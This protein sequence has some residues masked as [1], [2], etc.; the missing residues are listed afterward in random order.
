MSNSINTTNNLALTAAL[1]RGEEEAFRQLFDEYYYRLV[2]FANRLLNDLDLSRSTVQ[3]VF[4][5]LFDK[6]DEITVHTSLNALLHQMVRNRCL[7]LLKRDKMKRNHHQQIL[8]QVDEIEQ[9]LETLE[10]NE[11]ENAIH[12]IVNDLPAQCQRI[13]KLS[14][15]QGKSNQEI[16]DKL[17]LSKRTVE[18]QISNAL[19]QLRIG[20]RRMQLMPLLILFCFLPHLFYLYLK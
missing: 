13:F 2:V 5:V 17:Q 4:V 6:K 9:P 18:T 14:R 15:Y 19:K 1:K 12:L 20:L 7:N 3:D 16:A 8:L 11:L 10:Y